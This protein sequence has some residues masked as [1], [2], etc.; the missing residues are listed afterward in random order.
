MFIILLFWDQEFIYIYIYSMFRLNPFHDPFQVLHTYVAFSSR[1][2]QIFIWFKH[3][4][5]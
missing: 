5:P 4:F 3:Q 1:T 2:S